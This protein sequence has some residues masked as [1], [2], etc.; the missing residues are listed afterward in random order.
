MAYRLWRG[1]ID[2]GAILPLNDGG[3][4][5]EASGKGRL[6]ASMLPPDL[7]GSM[8]MRHT[9]PTGPVVLQFATEPIDFDEIKASGPHGSTVELT[10]AHT[11]DAAAAASMA[12]ELILTVRDDAGRVLPTAVVSLERVRWPA[13][14]ARGTGLSRD[15]W[16]V[17]WSC[18]AT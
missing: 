3:V 18:A 4:L 12:E 10:R 13:E 8:Q 17:V 14:F 5:A 15:Q 11:L 16:V 7:T 1:D 6:E 9:M 2:L